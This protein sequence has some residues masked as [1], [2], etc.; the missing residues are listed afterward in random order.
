MKIS[1]LDN[2]TQNVVQ[3]S[4]GAGEGVSL[5]P[6]VNL[7]LWAVYVLLFFTAVVQGFRTYQE[8]YQDKERKQN[9]D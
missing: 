9:K 3:A 8:V 2:T 1:N 5:A 6:A 4:I 7:T